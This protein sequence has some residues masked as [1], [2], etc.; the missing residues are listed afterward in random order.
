MRNKTLSILMSTAITASLVLPVSTANATSSLNQSNLYEAQIVAKTTVKGESVTIRSITKDTVL[1]TNG[2][3][4]VKDSLKPLFDTSNKAALTNAQATLV[5][6]NG[7]ITDVTALTLNKAGT[8]KKSVYFD[9]GDAQISGNLTVNADYMKIQ[10]VTV[11]GQLIITNKVKKA[12]TLDEVSVGETITLKPLLTKKANWLYVTLIDTKAAHVDLTRTKVSVSSN[13][14][15]AKVDITGDV[16]SFEVMGDVEK[17]TINVDSNFSLYGEGKIE[18]VIVE[19]GKKVALDSDHYVNKV[20]VD[21]QNV[22][23][24][25]PVVDKK[26]LNTLLA[27]PP[28][29][30]VSIN[31]YDVLTTEKWT[32]QADRTVFETAVASARAVANNS[33]A[34]QEQVKNAIS[35]YKNALAVYQAVQKNGTKYGY[36]DKASLQS[37]IHSVQYVSVS[38]YN[39][40]DIYNNAPWTT[41]AEKNAL[42]SAVSSAQAVVNN[43][44]ATQ[45]EIV[46]ATTQLN[47][48]IW[49][50]KNAY[51]YGTNGYYVD[52]TNL[53]TLINSANAASYGVIISAYGDGSDVSIY[54]YWTTQYDLNT[55]NS[56]INQA[57]TVFNNP[58]STQ[59]EISTAYNN[60]N[61]ALSNF[62]LAKRYKSY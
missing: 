11:D 32:T 36:G 39:G 53:Q 33:S 21:N 6:K 48:A 44:N 43:Y 62:N 30:H 4:K 25:L 15:I 38:W 58:Y 56:Y 18:Q 1:T 28:Y 17:L 60:L 3:F 45:N 46:N 54:N 2:T 40:S 35:H 42:E 31:G 57:N 52:K 24:T 5:V 13:Q 19:G 59:N 22:S 51:K 29:V 14:T 47:N 12:I 10:E 26:E 27:S 55:L 34:S 16:P 8:N 49:I 7:Q 23:V 9:A 37:L 50:Y 41:Q 20:Q 61:S